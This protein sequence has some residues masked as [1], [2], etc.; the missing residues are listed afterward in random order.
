MVNPFPANVPLLYPLKTSE[1]SDIFWGYRSGIL[2]E[3]G[4]MRPFF[5]KNTLEEEKIHI[6]RHPKA[7]RAII[8]KRE[9]KSEIKKDFKLLESNAFVSV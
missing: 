6:Y 9:I 7:R 8:R 2:V 5:P 3:N 4:L 1:I